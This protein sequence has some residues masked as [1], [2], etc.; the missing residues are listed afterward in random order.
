[1]VLSGLPTVTSDDLL[2]GRNA[3]RT[4]KKIEK[5]VYRTLDYV[6]MLLTKNP[7]SFVG[8]IYKREKDKPIYA[9]PKTEIREYLEGLITSNLTV[10]PQYDLVDKDSPENRFSTPLNE[11]PRI[12]ERTNELIDVINN[13]II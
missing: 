9:Q 8:K 13:V 2:T 3:D 4:F 5:E 7:K 10:V 6:G 1:M 11:V 12:T